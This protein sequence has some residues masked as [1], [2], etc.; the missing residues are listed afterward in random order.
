MSSGL[1]FLLCAIFLIWQ[2]DYAIIYSQEEGFI[3]G[4]VINMSTLRPVPFATIKLKNNQL[5]VYANADGDFKISRN[6]DFKD[7]SLLISCIGY[8]QSSIAYRDLIK[9]RINKV[10][11]SPVVYGLSEVKVVASLPKF[12]SLAIIRRAIRNIA[13]NYPDKPFSYIS[14]YRDYQKKD[15]DYLNLNEA[16]VQTLDD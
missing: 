2:S 9:T 14:Y 7:D 8:K 12:H 6:D 1:R 15:S 16:I 5:G 4:K 3:D 10:F 11:L 13:D